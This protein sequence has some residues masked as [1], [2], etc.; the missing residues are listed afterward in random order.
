MNVI[1]KIFVIEAE[2]IELISDMED[3]ITER[4]EE[5]VFNKE[6][7]KRLKNLC[8]DIKKKNKNI[9]KKIKKLD[10]NR[11]RTYLLNMIEE[12]DN[13]LSDTINAAKNNSSKEVY[14]NLMKL[15][16][17][18]DKFGKYL[19]R[20]IQSLQN[21]IFLELNNNLKNFLRIKY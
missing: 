7:F 14:E 21:E 8:E 1:S 12:R 16:D 9:K 4:I 18:M 10:K 2:I 11:D 15:P 6:D 5:G 19:G 17:S 3:L 13:I 20:I